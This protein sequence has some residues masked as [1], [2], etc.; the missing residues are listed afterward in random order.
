MSISR[1]GKGLYS[2][3]CPGGLEQGT[4]FIPNLSLSF[5]STCWTMQVRQDGEAVTD[6]QQTENWLFSAHNNRQQLAE[7][8]L[9]LLE[10]FSTPNWCQWGS[11]L[12]SCALMD[13]KGCVSPASRMNWGPLCTKPLIPVIYS[14]V[15]GSR[16]FISRYKLISCSRSMQNKNCLIPYLYT[17]KLKHQNSYSYFSCTHATIS[18]SHLVTWS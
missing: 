2:P 14:S 7:C 15:A 4:A 9:R 17:H 1:G 10:C 5:S 6:T 13:Q 3:S 12:T 11:E 16:P 18:L 8:K